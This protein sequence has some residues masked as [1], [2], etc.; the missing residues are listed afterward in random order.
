MRW[1]LDDIGL[2]NWGVEVREADLRNA[3]WNLLE[4]SLRIRRRRGLKQHGAKGWLMRLT[5]GKY[6]HD[7]GENPH[8]DSEIKYRQ[9]LWSSESALNDL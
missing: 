1:F 9:V 3:W 7:S 2:Q 4:P 5:Q 8:F 6:W